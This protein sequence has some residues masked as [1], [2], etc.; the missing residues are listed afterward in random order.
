MNVL[1]QHKKAMLRRTTAI[2]YVVGGLSTI[3]QAQSNQDVQDHLVENSSSPEIEVSAGLLNKELQKEDNRTIQLNEKHSLRNQDACRPFIVNGSLQPNLLDPVTLESIIIPEPPCLTNR[4]LFEL[5]DQISRAYAAAGFINSG[6]VISFREDQGAELRI[7]EGSLDRIEVTF[8]RDG[9][10]PQL[11]SMNREEEKW[12]P[13]QLRKSYVTSR[14]EIDDLKPLNQIDVQK[15]FQSLVADPNIRKISA[16]LEPTETLGK[17]NLRLKIEPENPVWVYASIASE[18]APS[19]GGS[20]AA[21]GGGVRNLIGYGDVLTA[22]FGITEGLQDAFANYSLPIGNSPYSV[23]VFGEYADAEIIEEPLTNLN[24]LS[25]S[26][27]YGVSA[28]SKLLGDTHLSC[29]QSGRGIS[30]CPANYI[31]ATHYNLSASLAIAEKTSR[32]ELLGIP[33]SFSPGAVNG[34]TRNTV[35]SA[36]LQGVTRSS[37]RVIAGRA[38]LTYG[39]DSLENNQPASPPQNFSSLLVQSQFAQQISKKRGDQVI[40]RLDV[41]YSP[42]TLFTNERYAFGGIDSVR[43][44]RKNDILT[45]NAVVASIEYRTPLEPA[46]DFLSTRFFDDWTVGVF[47]DAGH[48]WNSSLPDPDLNQ[49]GSIGLQLNFEMFDKVSGSVY[50]GAKLNNPQFSR[51]TDLQDDGIGFRIRLMGF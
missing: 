22:E 23:N 33:F 27:A 13:L 8:T 43:G 14:F 25:E 18:R 32:S 40:A 20:R 31:N 48:G 6:A 11:G 15:K 51:D 17:A 24:I 26:T 2:A 45:D 12:K 16:A 39:L 50:Y 47:A 36:S 7:V 46:V 10:S 37:N 49:I 1:S 4:D 34:E 29:T 9:V 3:A 28:T 44:F 19:I 30:N 38:V 5:K 35:L 21:F 41:Q 42:D